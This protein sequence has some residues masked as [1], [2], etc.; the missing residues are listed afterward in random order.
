[1]VAYLNDLLSHLTVYRYGSNY[2]E[3]AWEP[4]VRS[5]DFGV[6]AYKVYVNGVWDGVTINPNYTSSTMNSSKLSLTPGTAYSFYVTA[7][8]SANVETL[9]SNTVNVTTARNVDVGKF[10]RRR[11]S[12][13]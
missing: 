13:V 1:M 8:D 11:Y 5:T 10:K 9:P 12:V 2:V 7:V 3:L 6:K 4:S